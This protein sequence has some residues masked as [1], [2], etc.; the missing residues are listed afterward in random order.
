MTVTLTDNDTIAAVLR[1]ARKKSG[2]TGRE[3]A[4]RAGVSPSTI[5]MLENSR[6]ENP[7]FDAMMAVCYALGVDPR[8]L[9]QPPNGGTW[10]QNILHRETIEG[11]AGEMVRQILQRAMDVQFSRSDW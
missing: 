7:A 3:V 8:S 11:V 10:P 9:W 2:M 4:A 6:I 5:S 1:A